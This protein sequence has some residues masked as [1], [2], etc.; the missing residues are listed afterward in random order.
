ML[1]L[2]PGPDPNA[3]GT[4]AVVLAV[5]VGGAFLAVAALLGW[6]AVE[7][8]CLLEHYREA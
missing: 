3:F 7:L 2:M 8:A 1:P 4:L 6:T 5:G